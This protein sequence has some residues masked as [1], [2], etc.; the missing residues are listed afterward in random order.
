MGM[1][2]NNVDCRFA[3]VKNSLTQTRD[4]ATLLR[5]LDARFNRRGIISALL[6]TGSALT[7][8]SSSEAATPEGA[9][10]SSSPLSLATE[11]EA[12]KLIGEPNREFFDPHTQ[13]S[14]SSIPKLL[15]SDIK[16]APFQDWTQS[17]R[18]EGNATAFIRDSVDPLPD[19]LAGTWRADAKFS[20]VD[21]PLGRSKLTM[22]VAGARRM[23]LGFMPNVGENARGFRMRFNV[24]KGTEETANDGSV[25]PDWA[26]NVGSS[27]SAFWK[28]ASLVSSKFRASTNPQRLTLE[29]QGPTKSRKNVQ[30]GLAMDFVHRET[31]RVSNDIFVCGEDVEQENIEQRLVTRF[32]HVQSFERRRDGSVLSRERVAAFANPE[33]DR[34]LYEEAHGR[35]IAVYEYYYLLRPLQLFDH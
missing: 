20:A 23:S 22:T 3:S 16:K 32:T 27:L 33:V 13:L 17:F 19:W 18:S 10:K 2:S 4:A 1:Q 24:G 34:S 31:Q 11:T 12:S 15:F 26:F 9:S 14:L 35:P 21:F 28:E 6:W 25:Q 5:H 30:Q 8:A 29:Y 7:V